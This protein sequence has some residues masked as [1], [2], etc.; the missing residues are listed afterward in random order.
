VQGQGEAEMLAGLLNG[1]AAIKWSDGDSYDGYYKAGLREGKGIMKLAN[2]GYDG[3]WKAG[4]M[5]GKGIMRWF[6][7]SSYDGEFKNGTMEGRGTYKWPDGMV[8]EGGWKAGLREGKGIMKWPDGRVYDGEWKA[9]RKEGKGIGKEPDGSIYNGE[10]KADVREGKGI[11]TWPAGA[12]YNGDWKNNTREG[13]GTFKFPDGSVYT[14][15]FKNNDRN[16][17]GVLK[18]ATGKIMYEGEWKDDKPVV[19]SAQLKGEGKDNKPVTQPTQF[20]T[21][22]VLDMPWGA[23][24]D[25]AKRIMGQRPKTS[26]MGADTDKDVKLHTWLTYLGYYNDNEA[27]LQVHFYEG[28][29]FCVMASVYTSEDQLLNKLNAIKQGLTQRYGSPA[30][31]KGKYLDTK[32]QWDLGG[33]YLILMAI[34]QSTAFPGKPF[35]IMVLYRNQATQDL[36]NKAGAPSSGRDY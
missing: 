24:V 11:I 3:D 4:K 33:D 17:R 14:G 25:E 23:S 27:R 16:G 7:G 9:G 10:W 2:G 19:Q 5:E 34:I 30:I 31:E 6:D 26:F 35:E 20:K 29:M 12:S 28:K 8:Y 15:A 13:I 36:I 22:K 18:D 21:D 32:I 1:K